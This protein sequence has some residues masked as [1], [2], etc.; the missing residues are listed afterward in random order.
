LRKERAVNQLLGSL[1][2]DAEHGSLSLQ[3]ARYLMIRPTLFVE[4]HKSVESY[5]GQEAANILSDTAAT[6]GAELSTRFRD[7]FGYSGDQVMH[8]VAFMLCE[9]G[10]G[11]ITVEMANFEGRELVFKVLDSPFAGVYGPSTQPVCHTLLGMF[12]GVAMTL[13]ESGASG[14]E[15]QCEAKGDTCCRFV[16]SAA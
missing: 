9:S 15:V 14:M 16:V 12:R 2:Y 10:W 7:V 1:S 13:F 5:L 3:S 8:A 6:E 4:L 11:A